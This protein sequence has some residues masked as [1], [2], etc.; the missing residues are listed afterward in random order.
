MADALDISTQ[1][2]SIACETK[3]KAR[4]CST[5]L[6]IFLSF[7]F[8]TAGCYLY[9]ILH[10]PTFIPPEFDTTAISG[11]PELLDELGF[12]YIDIAKGFSIGLCGA[13]YIEQNQLFLYF[14]NPASNDC[15]TLVLLVNPSGAEIGRSGVLKPGEY[16]ASIP[17]T[18]EVTYE[19]A[20]SILIKIITY[21]PETYESR[22]TITLNPQ[23][24]SK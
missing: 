24:Y 2:F 10:Q 3:K 16:V 12:N 21:E 9:Y 1:K 6:A 11:V 22:G 19:N 13:P 23:I 7:F 14:T 15:W 5:I 8:I 18:N 17:F 4:I 20:N